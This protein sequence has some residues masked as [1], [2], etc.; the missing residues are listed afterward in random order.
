MT[1]KPQMFRLHEW[2][3]TEVPISFDG[4]LPACRPEASASW[5]EP[6]RYLWLLAAAV[7]TFVY[8]SWLGVQL[9]GLHIFW[10]T[11]PILA[12]GVI[13]VADHLIGPDSDNPPDSILTWLEN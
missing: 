12:F 11:G 1:G 7:P 6:K 9:T 10:W 3:G 5:K 4:R 8:V 13:P 2:S